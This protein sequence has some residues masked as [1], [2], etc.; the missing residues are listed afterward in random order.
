[1]ILFL[2][3][4][5]VKIVYIY[6]FSKTKKLLPDVANPNSSCFMCWSSPIAKYANAAVDL[7]GLIVEKNQKND[8]VFMLF[9]FV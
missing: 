7:H 5:T 8:I 3:F 2:N 9:L 6:L 4:E 1:M